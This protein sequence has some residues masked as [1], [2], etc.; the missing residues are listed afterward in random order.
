M[1]LK[2]LVLQPGL[3][4]INTDRGAKGRYKNGNH[5]RFFQGLPQK[6]G[7]W[8]RFSTLSTYAGKARAV[9]DWQSLAVEKLISIG[10]HLK[11]Y[12]LSGGQ[13]ADITP[14]RESGTLGADPFETTNGSAVVNVSDTA[15]GL[16]AGD[17]VH[18]SGASAVG[19][20]TID[21]EYTV[22][23]VTNADKYTITHSAAATSDAVGGGASVDYEYEIHVGS[24][25]STLGL[26]WGAGA[27][28]GSTWGTARSVTN[29]LAMCRIWSFDNWGEDLIACPRGGSIYV[30]DTSAGLASNRATLITQA[31]STAKAIFVSPENRHLVALG[32]H[33]GSNDDALLIRWCDSEDYTVWTEDPTVTAGQKRIDQGNEIYCGVKTRGETLIFTDSAIV[34]MKFEGPPYTFGFDYIGANGGLAGPNAVKEFNGTVYWMGNGNFFVYDGQVNPLPCEVLNHVFDDINWTQRAKVYAGA[35]RRYSEVW[36]LYC[37]EDSTEC[38]AYV[39]YNTVEKTWS[40]GTLARTVIVADSDT[41]EDPYAAGTD[42]YLYYHEQGTDANGSAMTAYVESGDID[43]GEGE[44]EMQIKKLVPDF[45]TLDGSVSVTL[46]GKRYPQASSTRTTGPKTVTSST[47]Y[48]NPR[49]RA[50]QVSIRIESSAVGDDWR[51][52]I[53]RVELVPHGKKS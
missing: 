35:N 39:L 17:Y 14:I 10:T 50:R 24:G 6:I 22:T 44:Y 46:N 36:W 27:W 25:D 2:D 28:G 52:G 4:T 48:I 43:I 21:G 40:F 1:P 20:I 37:T 42:G 33:D 19:G 32:A 53:M 26:G 47:E 18:Y 51:M 41:F 30:W 23:S 8:E 45:V 15:H 11:L 34:A 9:I 29:F 16:L 12:V 3:Y 31:P 38:D 7:G 49:M 5:V 13:L